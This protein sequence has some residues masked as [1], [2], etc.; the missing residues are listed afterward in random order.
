[1]DDR[2]AESADLEAYRK[3]VE[4]LAR[5]AHFRRELERKLTARGFDEEVAAGACARLER[6]GYLDDAEA[7]RQL[8]GGALTRKGYGPARMRAELLR[9]GAPEEA[10]AAAAVAAFPDGEAAA[11]RRLAESWVARRGADRA[12]LARHLERKGYGAGVIYELVDELAEARPESAWS[13]R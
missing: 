4:L 8:A 5:R 11:A 2:T 7:A 1:M 9:R 6:E 3:A 13:D 12:A 10:A